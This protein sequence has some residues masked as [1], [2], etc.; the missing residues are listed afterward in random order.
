MG[1]QRG[2][3]TSG[4]CDAGGGAQAGFPREGRA[5]GLDLRWVG[6]CSPLL[7]NFSLQFP[8]FL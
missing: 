6:L 3:R 2:V 1:T 4:C 8:A 7:L 5:A